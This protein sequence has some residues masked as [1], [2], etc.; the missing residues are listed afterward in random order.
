MQAPD[1]DAAQTVGALAALLR[2]PGAEGR[3]PLLACSRM[4]VNGGASDVEDVGDLLDGA[5]AGVVE[6]LGKHDLLGG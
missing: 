3:L 2:G 5:L 6:L 1:L 4:S